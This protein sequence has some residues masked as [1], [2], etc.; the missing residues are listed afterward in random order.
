M[1]LPVFLVDLEAQTPRSRSVVGWGESLLG[2]NQM[3]P[4]PAGTTA[5]DIDAL[6]SGELVNAVG[7]RSGISGYSGPRIIVSGASILTGDAVGR[8]F[9]GAGTGDFTTWDLA[10][11][12]T[13]SGALVPDRVSFGFLHAAV[14]LPDGKMAFVGD[15]QGGYFP[16]TPA[17]ANLVAV[18]TSATH[19]LGLRANGSVVGIGGANFFGENTVPVGLSGAVGV[20]AG[21]YFSAAVLNNGQVV[22]WGTDAN[23]VLQIPATATNIVSIKAGATHLVAL[24]AD[25]TVIAWGNAADGRTS[26][27]TGLN[28]VAKIAV[29]RAHAVALRDDGTVAAWGYNGSGQA[30]IPS[31]LI[32]VI[33]IAA[34]G[35]HSLA[36]MAL[37]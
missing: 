27:P 29:G 6:A 1:F 9:W 32:N 34:G 8:I 30:S 20:A 10:V 11:V 16:A 36:R 35:N 24:R 25:G 31:G 13:L 3:P 7:L 18:A 5:N 33:D 37:T 23:G 14:I 12:N 26:V 17:D 4:L 22:V 28:R 21:E 15:R 19:A 2:L